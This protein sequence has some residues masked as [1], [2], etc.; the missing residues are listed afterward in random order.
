MSSQERVSVGPGSQGAWTPWLLLACVL[1]LLAM[2]WIVLDRFAF[3]YTDDDQSIMWYG[4]MEMARGRFHEPCF[5]G[6]H[7]NTMLEGLLAV[8]MLWLGVG[9]E[10]ALPLVT[11]SIALFPYLLFAALSLRAGRTTQAALVLALPMCLPPEFDLVCAIPRGFMTGCFL[12]SLAVL[13]IFFVHRAML[14]ACGAMVVFAVYANPNALVVLVPAVSYIG[15]R[16]RATHLAWIRSMAGALP[17][18]GLCYWGR[19]FYVR[20]PE[21]VVHREWSLDFDP[22]RITVQALD[23]SLGQVTPVLWGKGAMVLVV[24]VI[25]AVWLWRSRQLR[26]AAVLLAGAVLMVVSI[27][28]NKVHDGIPSV[29]YAWTRMYVAVPLLLALCIA[30]TD[31]VP[32]RM[33]LPLI[34]VSAIVAFG[35]KA[36]RLPE[37]IDK[38]LASG[39]PRNVHVMAVGELRARCARIS[40]VAWMYHVDLLVIGWEPEK[41]LTNYGCPCLVGRFPLAIQPELDRRTWLLKEVEPLRVH[42]LLLDGADIAKLR[43]RAPGNSLLRRIPEDAKLALLE[44]PGMAAGSLLDSLGLEMRPH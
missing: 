41:H 34:T 7:Y 6:Q 37:V 27:G 19:L 44:V 14:V 5:Y 3:R 33:W 22:G 28:V 24:M 29:F 1:L 2:R 42:R 16:Y 39:H 4:A 10:L 8:P 18:M 36:Y 32:G 35:I 12:A 20:H 21:H 13:P 38:E 9:P 31:G 17:A 11:G 43:G 15:W 30:L 23:R 40:A 26:A 25:S